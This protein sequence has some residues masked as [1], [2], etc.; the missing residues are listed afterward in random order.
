MSVR[1]G[2]AI[3]LRFIVSSPA[4]SAAVN[5]DALPVGTLVRNGANTAEVVTIA[6]VATGDYS[7]SFT[8]PAG[9]AAGDEVQLLIAATVGG[10]AGKGYIWQA[11]LDSAAGTTFPAGAINFTYTIT[12]SV[13]ALPIE[14]VEVWI[15]TDSPAVNIV[16][17]GDTDAFGVARDVNGNLPALDAGTYYFWRQKAGYIFSDPDTEV[18]S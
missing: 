16:W 8:I 14:G 7:A 11:S 18:V 17:K 3:S 6:N 1:P 9:Y 10:V 4:T 13:T 12:D 15:S 2:D 5:A